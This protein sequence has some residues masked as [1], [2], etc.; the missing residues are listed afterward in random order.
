M[1]T[2]TKT[3]RIFVS[4]TFSDMRHERKILQTEVFP[5]LEALCSK[6]GAQFQAVDL[7]WGVNEE[8]QLSQKTMD[9]CLQEIERCQKI[10]PK[11]NF[12]VLLGDRYGWQPIP[13]K[14]PSNEM[15]CILKFV[16]I[17]GKKL[18]EQWYWLDENALPSE[19]VLQ[20][21]N[22][23]FARYD[24]WAPVEDSI[25]D[26]LRAAA[27][28][29]GFTGSQNVKY[30]ASATHQEIFAGAFFSPANEAKGNN[31]PM[32][33]LAMLRTIRDLP[34]N[35]S[36]KEYTDI[37]N[38]SIDPYSKTRLAKLRT[39]LK[40]HL[41]DNC[42]EYSGIWLNGG[43]DLD[44]SSGFANAVY[45]HFET[46]ITK[47]IAEFD[48]LSEG[49]LERSL[50]K[51]FLERLTKVAAGRDN[52]LQVIGNYI[53]NG[54][55]KVLSI[56]GESGSGK[57]SLMA[58]AISKVLAKFDKVIYRFLGIS[59]QSSD[60]QGLLSSLCSE[61]CDYFNLK[62]EDLFIQNISEDKKRERYAF[63]RTENG[64]KELFEKCF[65]F[66]RSEKPLIVFID[67][68]DQLDHPIKLIELLSQTV[69][70]SS[71]VCCI[72]SC[73]PKYEAAFSNSYVYQ[74]PLLPEQDARL[75]LQGY[76]FFIKRKLTAEQIE[77]ILTAFRINGLPI[78][79][80]LAFE[81]ARSWNSY[82]KIAPLPVDVDGMLEEFYDD[83]ERQHTRITVEKAIGYMVCGRYG[84]L[85]EKEI[86]EMLVRDG[87]HWEAFLNRT[88]ASHRDEVRAANILPS[89]IWARLYLDLEPYL[90]ERNFA[91]TSVVTFFH[92]HFTEFSKKRFV[93][94][95][96]NEIGQL[97][98][99]N[100]VEMF[101]IQPL[102]L[103][104][105]I[106][107]GIPNTRKCVELPFQLMLCELWTEL[108]NMLC[109]ICY[110]QAVAQAKLL[111]TLLKDYNSALEILPSDD[112]QYCISSF[113]NVLLR[114]KHLFEKYPKQTFQDIYNEMQWQDDSIKERVEGAR[115]WFL[116]H[117]GRFLHQ[118]RIPKIE[119]TY[120][121]TT[122][123]GHSDAV[124]SCAFSP[125]NNWIVS[126]SRDKTL[127]IWN[128]KTFKEVFSLAGHSGLVCAC[129]YSPDGRRIVSASYDKTIKI[130]NAESG[131]HLE[132]LFGHADVVRSCMYSPD[133]NRIVSGSSDGTLIIW[134]AKTGQK[135]IVLKHVGGVCSCGYSPNG[136]QIVSGGYDRT[137][138]IWDAKI[139]N[140]IA[141]FK[142]EHLVSTIYSCSYSP[143]GRKVVF[144]GRKGTIFI[145]NIETKKL[146]SG[147]K[148]GHTIKSC[149]YSPDGCQI[150][151]LDGRGT[152]KISN[153]ETGNQI[154]SFTGD[155]GSD[156]S[157]IFSSD[158]NLIVGCR[159][160]SL[161][162]WSTKTGHKIPSLIGHKTF[163]ESLAFSPDSLRVVSVGSDPWLRINILGGSKGSFPELKIWDS[164]KGQEILELK[165]IENQL[166]KC[167]FSPDCRRVVSLYTCLRWSNG[168]TVESLFGE[169]Q[170]NNTI[171]IWD[172]ENGRK[173]AT[174]KGRD[175]LIAYYVFSPD[176]RLV[177][178]YSDDKV[179]KIWNTKINNWISATLTGHIDNINSIS[180]SPD[181]NRLL[182]CSNDKTLKIW[183]V[184]TGNCIKD[185]SG[186]QASVNTCAYSPDGRLIVSGSTDGILKIWNAKL[187]WEITT[188]NG[189]K[190]QVNYC[191]FLPDGRRI[192]SASYDGILKI[193][194]VESGNQISSIAKAGFE[195]A[196]TSDGSQIVSIDSGVLKVFN[197]ESG[198][199]Q[200]V[201]FCENEVTSFAVSP[202]SPT[203]ACGDSQGN[204]Y[205][206]ELEG[207]ETIHI[208]L[209]IV[210]PFR[211]ASGL[212]ARCP[213]C[214]T[215]LLVPSTSK[216]ALSNFHQTPTINSLTISPRHFEDENPIGE[217]INCHKQ[218]KYNLFF[219]DVKKNKQFYGIVEE[220]RLVYKQQLDIV[221]E[222]YKTDKESSEYSHNYCKAIIDYANILIKTQKEK[223]ALFIISK[224]HAIMHKIFCELAWP[225]FAVREN[226]RLIQA[227][228]QVIKQRYGVLASFKG[229]SE[230][231]RQL[232]CM[233]EIMKEKKY[234]A[235]NEILDLVNDN[236][237]VYHLF[238][239]R[240]LAISREF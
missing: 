78:F 46:I 146:L 172:S 69:E 185:L 107:Q 68:L 41:G 105:T 53:A 80:R 81:L 42:R 54:D 145:W 26:I 106:G 72:V 201:F 101:S 110:I 160:N 152:L 212:F 15:E 228:R 154:I 179:I 118:F 232:I 149:V 6:A 95:E 186:H 7:R 195:C 202:C 237:K 124:F 75:I 203:I 197:T 103:N 23:T 214:G 89:V 128:A 1:P 156:G 218:I 239:P 38:H 76:L 66:A 117:G 127:K 37:K 87:E 199:I 43:V 158:C 175:N 39:A 204:I 176:G 51:G 131:Q 32:H 173:I 150:A 5:K 18:L 227:E 31:A 33:V 126:A 55:K 63:M 59:S 125:D 166:S 234:G 231:D 229:I 9:I 28:Q 94:Y 135:I 208:T 50:Q 102:F 108:I 112:F 86:A 193:W 140:E 129:G 58:M 139:G 93:G 114:R 90:T 100:L 157:C 209:P 163:V 83:L 21:R 116:N 151:S 64:L 91:G 187:G 181:G 235:D 88:H 61:M 191:A 57:S 137:L 178:L 240:A 159:S 169:K 219:V 205:F 194:D 60:L 36:A 92:M 213:F 73:L 161:K 198:Q 148:H 223:E 216:G 133:G 98:H 2:Q 11:P 119:K 190:S 207:Y 142:N 34:D 141:S 29:C 82:S 45:N 120:E 13:S 22:I 155:G 79:L 192:V 121:I 20:P 153:A 220:V 184:N 56:I 30:F 164:K 177:A 183:D 40:D 171:R 96:K 84:G 65:S 49:E 210:T 147:C 104:G 143:D 113:K 222:R 35:E 144:G 174:F 3:F 8:S 17:H 47:Q 230:L 238:S 12:L 62:A 224:K 188:I 14:I 122:L 4:S 162:I 196:F 48:V 167:S 180:F 138:R 225:L 99:K 221:S 226:I 97:L 24:D 111:D 134:N 77:T 182:S 10:S 25:R 215:I 16:D 130:W 27:S 217:C 74:L 44:D 115:K 206:V 200:S 211:H 165:G 19:Y 109:D 85:T 52:D 168:G 236:K 132:T 123:N 71:F 233:A 189:H 136:L 170:E 70:K 67:A